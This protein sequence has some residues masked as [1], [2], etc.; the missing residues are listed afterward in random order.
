MTT[1]FFNFEIYSRI[2]RGKAHTSRLLHTSSGPEAAPDRWPGN[3]HTAALVV[4]SL[5][6]HYI[7]SS[8]QKQNHCLFF[9]FVEE[10]LFL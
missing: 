5:R 2:R 1:H 6:H 7:S 4:D 10:N 8:F 9:I 3:E